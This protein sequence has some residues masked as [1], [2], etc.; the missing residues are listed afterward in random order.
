M[1]VLLQRVRQA[2]V[3]I[4]GEKVAQIGRGLV[5]FVGI[6]RG[7]IE[8]DAQYLVGKTVNL[9]LFPDKEGRLNLSALEINGEVLVVS[10]FTL[11]ADTRKGRRPSFS[12]AA[13]PSEAE[14]LF[15]RFVELTKATGL[16]VETG[17]FQ[18]HMLVEIQNE[19]PVTILLDSKD[20]PLKN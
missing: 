2:S 20:K 5:A 19:G 11:L 4:G 8:E 1:K 10:Q 13:L 12:Q 16:K 7:D 18:Q 3:S 9:R 17:R 6:A 15:Q 14:E